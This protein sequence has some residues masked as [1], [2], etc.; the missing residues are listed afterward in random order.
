MTFTI[1]GNHATASD[2]ALGMAALILNGKTWQL[3]FD[4]MRGYEKYPLNNGGDT[5]AMM[6]L[7][8]R[9]VPAFESIADDIEAGKF[10]DIEAVGKALNERSSPIQDR[11]EKELKA[12]QEKAT[13]RP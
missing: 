7:L 9:Y 1:N 13:S 3:D 10:A 8:A 4:D 12:L 11:V 2:N 6:Y 5:A